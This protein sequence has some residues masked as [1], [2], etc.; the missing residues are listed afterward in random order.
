MKL[1]LFKRAAD[2]KWVFGQNID[3]LHEPGICKPIPST[4]RET[5]TIIYFQRNNAN[6]DI[7][8]QPVTDFLKENGD[9]YADFAELS[10]AYA[11]FFFSVDAAFYGGF[12]TV[13]ITG[14]GVNTDYAMPVDCNI[15]APFIINSDIYSAELV[16]VSGVKKI[17]F[18]EVLTDEQFPVVAYTPTVATDPT[19]R[20][21]QYTAYWTQTG[22]NAPVAVEQED[23]IEPV[24]ARSSAGVYTATK[25]GA[26]VEGKTVPISESY[27]DAE[28]GNKMKMVRT[29]AD[30]MTITTYLA[31]DLETPADGVLTNQYIHFEIFN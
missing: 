26:F 25:A 11:D 14:D 28:T 16:L 30:V 8:N 29:S 7:F 18:S 13:Q 6:P 4:N 27:I 1:Y 15:A 22:T 23:D 17:R 5:I 21:K 31:A 19:T 9:A 24:L 10:D 12:K 3:C 2:D 20:K